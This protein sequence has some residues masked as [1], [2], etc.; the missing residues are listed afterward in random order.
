MSWEF[1]NP[2]GVPFTR[3][4]LIHSSLSTFLPPSLPPFLPPSLLPLQID[5]SSLPKKE[6]AAKAREDQEAARKRYHDRIAELQG[7]ILPPSHPP[8]LTP[9]PSAPRLSRTHT[10]PPSLPPSLPG[11]VERMQPNMRA[12]EKYEE[13]GRRVKE[14]GREGGRED[15]RECW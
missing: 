5:F 4:M 3:F 13:M 12:L 7:S 10:L 11:E 9:R 8:P 15:G 14:V 1:V 2:G 6:K